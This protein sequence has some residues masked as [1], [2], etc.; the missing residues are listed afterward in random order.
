MVLTD[1]TFDPAT[2]H[3]GRGGVSDHAHV[4]EDVDALR[5]FDLPTPCL[6]SYR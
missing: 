5:R 4:S 2:A 3:A 6:R 1:Y